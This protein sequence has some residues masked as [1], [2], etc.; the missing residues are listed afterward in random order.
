MVFHMPAV[1]CR[2]RQIYLV[3]VT[4]CAVAI[5][6]GK[7]TSWFKVD[8]GLRQGCLLSPTLFNIFL[9]FVMKEV[10]DVEKT[11][12][13][14]PELSLNI[15]YADD[16]TLSSV[17]FDKLA[18]TTKQLDDA[19]RKWGMKING[20]K[21]KIMSPETTPINLDGNKLEHVDNFVFL[22]SQ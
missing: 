12:S 15:R 21:C 19:C 14:S 4:E 22:G 1:Y 16:T 3:L 11:L 10:K 7:I 13:L 9:E 2:F 20:A 5:D 8:V 6:Y 17:I 18:L